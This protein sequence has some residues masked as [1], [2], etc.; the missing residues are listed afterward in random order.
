M[1]MSED[2]GV[3]RLYDYCTGHDACAPRQ[4]ET[5]SENVF[6]NDRK[7][8]RVTDIYNVHACD[9]H[10]PHNDVIVGGSSRVF[11]ND[12]PIARITDPVSLG[13]N[14][15]TCSVDVFAGD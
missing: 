12:K 1:A 14:V 13:G 2:R 9:A 11:V 3:T 5:G 4:Q 8:G 15:M 6:I 10:P 7:C